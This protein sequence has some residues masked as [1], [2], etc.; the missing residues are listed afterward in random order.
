MN[1]EFKR[2]CWLEISTARLVLMPLLIGLA[3]GPFAKSLDLLTSAALYLSFSGFVA[4]TICWGSFQAGKAFPQEF[5]E[6]TWDSQRMSA[7]TPWQMV[8][9]KLFGSTLYAWYGGAILLVLGGGSALW[10]D[11]P[12]MQIVALIFGMICMALIVHASAL[13][14]ALLNRRKRPDSDRHS[15]FG[16]L[17]SLVLLFSLLMWGINSVLRIGHFSLRDIEE[18]ILWWGRHWDLLNFTTVTLFSLA[19]WALIGLWETMRR[20]LMLHNRVWWWPLFLLFWLIWSAGFV[21][22]QEDWHPFFAGWSLAVGFTG[23]VLLF[24][25]RKD[26][27]M[28]LRIIAASRNPNKQLLQHLEPGW[29]TSFLIAIG[30]GF[31]AVLLSPEKI[32][33]LITLLCGCAFVARDVAWVLWLNLEPNSRRADGAA[34]V[35][36]AVAYYLLPALFKSNIAFFHPPLPDVSTTS[37]L[38]TLFF[39]SIQAVLCGVLFYNRWRS[40]FHF[41]AEPRRSS[42]PVSS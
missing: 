21:P 2:N 23:Y 20:E 39:A 16:G 41:S 38:L 9:G 28:W 18:P 7:L 29:L 34:L 5:R 15:S 8:W 11:H 32:S 13:M 35:S 36:L 37:A 24:A 4:L 30:L 26:Q 25:V 22:S 19:L 1:P 12:P 40:V 14:R 3:L 42:S 17:F 33:Y 27:G 6:G 10:R 31:V